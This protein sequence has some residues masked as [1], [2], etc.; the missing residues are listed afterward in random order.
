MNS[1]ANK[2]ATP[3]GDASPP[4]PPSK[5]AHFWIEDGQTKIDVKCADDEPTKVCADVLMKIMD[6]LSPSSDAQDDEQD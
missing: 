5:A 4:P 2:P 6:K 3:G 1:P